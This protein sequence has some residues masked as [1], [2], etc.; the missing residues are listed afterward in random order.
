MQDGFGKDLEMVEIGGDSSFPTRS[1]IHFL[2]L[3]YSVMSGS[4]EMDSRLRGSDENRQFNK[5]ELR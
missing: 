3:Q 2:N 5:V 1:G 4:R